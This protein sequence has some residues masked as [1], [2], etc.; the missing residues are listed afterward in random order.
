MQVKL[1]R[2]YLN[3]YVFPDLFLNP[4]GVTMFLILERTECA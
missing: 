1:V 3:Y 4:L 2:T